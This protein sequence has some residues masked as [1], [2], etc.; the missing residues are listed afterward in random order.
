LFSQ[1]RAFIPVGWSKVGN[2]L[3]S[4]SMSTRK[5][6]LDG[7]CR[8]GSNALSPDRLSAEE[9]LSEIALILAAGLVRLRSRQSSR[10][11]GHRENSFVDFT[12]NQSGGVS[13][14]NSM[15]NAQ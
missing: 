15:E 7:L 8:A 9:R 4:L 13:V 5:S 3:P 14:V 12:A 11:S 6:T 10:L 1:R 2:R